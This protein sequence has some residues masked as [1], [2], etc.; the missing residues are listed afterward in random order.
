MSKLPVISGQDCMK[1][2]QKIG[3]VIRRQKGSHI[4][5]QRRDLYAMVIVPNHRTMKP[6]TL[7][8]IIQD[9]GMPVSQWMNSTPCWISEG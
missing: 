4:I 6:G 3:F 9:A 8:K 2:L 1:A 7:R 5:M